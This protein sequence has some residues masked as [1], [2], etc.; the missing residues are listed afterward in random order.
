MYTP[1]CLCACTH[2]HTLSLFTLPVMDDEGP[3]PGIDGPTPGVGELGI[4]HQ[5]DVQLS[6]CEPTLL[7]T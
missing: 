4:D 2:K 5:D 3:V 1:M 7:T 6:R